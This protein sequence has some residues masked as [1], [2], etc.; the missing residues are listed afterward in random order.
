MVSLSVGI[1]RWAKLAG[2][3]PYVKVIHAVPVPGSFDLT[4]ILSLVVNAVRSDHSKRA[5]ARA[6]A[7][8]CAWWQQCDH[9]T[10]SKAVIQQYRAALER[11]GLA[12]S[13][14]NLRL[15]AIRRLVAEAA[16]NRLIDHEIAVAITGVKGVKMS[17]VRTGHWLT[18]DQAEV[19]LSRPAAGTNR[20]KRDRVILALLVGCGL[21]RKE[22][23]QLT[24]EHIQQREGRWVVADLTGKGNRVRTVPMPSWAKAIL[25]QWA[26][27]LGSATGPILRRINK[28][29]AVVSA[30][31]TPQSVFCVVKRYSSGIEMGIA[32]HD[33]RR[34]FAKLAH[35][36]RAPLEQIQLSLGHSSVQTTERYLGVRQ[37]L[38]DAPCDHLGLNPLLDSGG[39]RA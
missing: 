27:A 3:I 24:F 37:D 17:G 5:Y 6:V 36:G 39:D 16:D 32:P 4:D 18:R 13:S 9:Q 15:S 1:T 12:P 25:D 2:P 35:R 29:D 19:L 11:R 34:T 22:L 28:R 14:I 21:R 26:N 20:G 8:F 38:A 30:G 33:L 31:I 10:L 23:T 7:D